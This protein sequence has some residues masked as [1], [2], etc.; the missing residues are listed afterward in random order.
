MRVHSFPSLFSLELYA[1]VR[2]QDLFSN[3]SL[4]L[5][6]VHNLINTIIYVHEERKVFFCTSG[7]ACRLLRKTRLL[8]GAASKLLAVGFKKQSHQFQ[9]LSPLVHEHCFQDL[10]KHISIYLSAHLSAKLS[11]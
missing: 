10:I 8:A 1:H 5:W 4:S 7:H 6:Q 2:E 11:R 9:L 3:C